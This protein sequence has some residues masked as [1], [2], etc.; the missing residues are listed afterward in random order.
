MWSSDLC[1]TI[2]CKEFV[3]SR[4]KRLLAGISKAARRFRWWWSQVRLR[5]Q[6]SVH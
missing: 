3:A 5:S 4:I 1:R 2:I 6:A